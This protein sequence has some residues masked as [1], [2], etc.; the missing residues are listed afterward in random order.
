MDDH[1]GTPLAPTWPAPL[2]GT[3][4]H[5]ERATIAQ[6]P[7]AARGA[8]SA[9]SRGMNTAIL[10]AGVLSVLPGCKVPPLPESAHGQYQH[11]DDHDEYDGWLFNRVTKQDQKLGQEKQ[12]ADAQKPSAST[13]SPPSQQQP[14][15]PPPSL[16]PSPYGGQQQ[17]GMPQS[18][19][20]QLPYAPQQQPGMPQSYGPQSPFEGQQAGLPQSPQ[21]AQ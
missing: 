20:P 15:T 2:H 3:V 11:V 1:A 19:G 12:L 6:P 13:Q 14:G 10:L 7:R 18:Y 17:P 9:V 8:S 4:R 16:Q 5:H 21:N